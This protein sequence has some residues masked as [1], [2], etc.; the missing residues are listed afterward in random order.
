MCSAYSD[1]R[2]C[3]YLYVTKSNTKLYTDARGTLFAE[4]CCVFSQTTKEQSYTHVRLGFAVCFRN[5]TFTYIFFKKIKYIYTYICTETCRAL[6]AFGVAVCF[7]NRT[8]IYIFFKK[9]KK[10][11][12][13]QRHVG[14]YLRRFTLCLRQHLVF[15]M[16]T[17][18][19][20]NTHCIPIKAYIGGGSEYPLYPYESDSIL[21]VSLSIL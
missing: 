14:F 19:D 5:R 13:I 12:H 21:W 7:H 4:F 17:G 10:H 20:R 11:L 2:A 3:M 6:C 16:N 8:Y 18:V 9:T 1:Q 15:D